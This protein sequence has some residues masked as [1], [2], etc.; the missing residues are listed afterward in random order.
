MTWSCQHEQEGT[1]R[2]EDYVMNLL[3]VNS[4]S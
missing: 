4:L 3:S 2:N 1:L